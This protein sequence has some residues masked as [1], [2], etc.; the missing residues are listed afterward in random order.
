MPPVLVTAEGE[1]HERILDETFPIWNDG[2]TR[3]RYGQY[4]AAQMR[5]RW[6]AAHLARVAL[7]EGDRVL[8]SAKRYDLVALLDGRSVRVVGVG[9]VFTPPELRGRG[10]G[11]AVVNALLDRARLDGCE[12][13]LLFSEIGPA[14]YERLGFTRVPLPSRELLVRQAAGA[15]AIA[16]RSGEIA[17][18]EPIADMHARRAAG[19]RFALQYQ[20]DWLQYAIARRRLFS[21]LGPAGVR[22]FEFLVAEEGGRAVAWVMLHVERSAA[23]LG[24]RWTVESCGDRD[25]T[26]ARIGALLQTALARSPGSAP[27]QILAWWP[28]ALAPPQLDSRPL[29]GSP[30]TMMVR[31]ISGAVRLVPPLGAH[32]VLYWHADAF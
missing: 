20:P 31:P 30:I 24:E 15:P 6:G 12:L 18:L 22:H 2:L 14:Y 8:A 13:A 11:R 10:H 9:A 1:L 5:T 17:D 28:A 7:V 4:N 23:G 32:D 25:P 16:V 21:G 26:G 19:F 3:P 29:Y 27:P